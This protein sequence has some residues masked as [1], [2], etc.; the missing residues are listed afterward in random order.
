MA[1]PTFHLLSFFIFHIVVNTFE[2]VLAL[3]KGAGLVQCCHPLWGYMTIAIPF[4]PGIVLVP[5]YLWQACHSKSMDVV[6]QIEEE[7]QNKEESYQEKRGRADATWAIVQ[8]LAFPI[9]MFVTNSKH[10]YR[11]CHLPQGS[12]ERGLQKIEIR[13]KSNS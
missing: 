8:W 6:T 7:S 3:I 1:S 11:L 10:F 12:F 9:T 5:W 2:T 13:E 4:L